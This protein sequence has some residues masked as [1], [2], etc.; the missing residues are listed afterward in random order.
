MTQVANDAH[1]RRSRLMLVVAVIILVL[2]ADLWSKQWAWDALRDGQRV[3]LIEQVLYFK[4][5]FNTGSAFS[6]LQDAAWS[7]VFFIAVTLL[8]LVYMGWLALHLSAQRR[9]GFVA[10]G[11]IAGGALGNLHDRFVRRLEV[12]LDGQVVERYG[13][14]DFIQ[15]YYHWDSGRY[16][17]I[18]NIA[19]AAL[20]CGVGLL[21]VHL[22]SEEKARQQAER[23]MAEDTGT[24]GLANS[25]APVD[26]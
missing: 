11:L 7:R 14:V 5:G 6:L 26:P 10:I 15:F 25:T 19:D 13:V 23:A 17:P 20:V 2:V 24:D 16:W 18:F 8:A 3:A 9:Y 22:W 21:L 12:P 1:A 4:F